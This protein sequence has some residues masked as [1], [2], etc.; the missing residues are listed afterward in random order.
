M[1]DLIFLLTGTGGEYRQRLWRGRCCGHDGRERF[2]TGQK[3][4]FFS[5]LA[6]LLI[7][8]SPD[9]YRRGNCPDTIHLEHLLKFL[10][11]RAN[12]SGQNSVSGILNRRSQK[13]A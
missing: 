13:E 8:L 9:H 12:P 3:S 4:R 10:L 6:G 2:R 11:E 7:I 5:G 1:H